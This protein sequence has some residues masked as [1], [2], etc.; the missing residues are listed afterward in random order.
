MR[1]T[2]YQEDLLRLIK[3][4]DNLDRKLSLSLDDVTG[5]L[6]RIHNDIIAALEAIGDEQ[7]ESESEYAAKSIQELRKIADEA[8]ESYADLKRRLDDL[9]VDNQEIRRCLENIQQKRHI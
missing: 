8:K 1:E 4:V 3:T 2:A 7:V 5:H 9:D 6:K